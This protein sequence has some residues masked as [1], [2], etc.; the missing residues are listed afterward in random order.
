MFLIHTVAFDRLLNF[1]VGGA[2][3]NNPF[4]PYVPCHRVVAS[5]LFIGGFCGEWAGRES[6]DKAGTKK[7]EEKEQLQIKRKIRFLKEEGVEVDQKGFLMDKQ[8]AV[9]RP[10]QTSLLA[11]D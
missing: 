2:L 5:N 4:S 1:V 9:W 11:E 10:A 3:R 6:S 8:S 7:L